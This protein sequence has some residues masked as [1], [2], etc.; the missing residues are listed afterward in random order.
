MGTVTPPRLRGTFDGVDHMYING[1]S[2]SGAGP[3]SYSNGA[4][5]EIGVWNAQ[6]VQAE[7][8]ML[9]LGY[10]PLFVRPQNLVAYLPIHSGAPLVDLKGNP[11]WAVDGTPDAFPHP[12]II[13]PRRGH[14]IMTPAEAAAAV[15]P[16]VTT[17]PYREA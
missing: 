8:T 10:S 7:W 14:L 2:I 5:A 15:I 13:Y 6:L 16:H 11:S 3:A 4:A 9:A 12:P 1:R 17:A